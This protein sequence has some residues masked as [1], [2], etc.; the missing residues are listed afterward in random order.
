MNVYGVCE[1]THAHVYTRMRTFPPR[2][3]LFCKQTEG[4][5]IVKYDAGT[6]LGKSASPQADG[7]LWTCPALLKFSWVKVQT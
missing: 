6:C 5:E 4:S 7:Q 3:A 2:E 1:R